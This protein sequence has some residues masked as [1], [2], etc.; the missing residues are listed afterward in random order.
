MNDPY[1]CRCFSID[2]L[3]ID[4]FK[5]ALKSIGFKYTVLQNENGFAFGLVL[6][7]DEYRRM[8]V[9]TDYDGN[10]EAEIEYR[11]N[12]PLEHTQ[13]PSYSAHADLKAILKMIDFN[14]K[15]KF[16]PPLSCL[17]PKPVIV[18]NPT[19]AK[20]LAKLGIIGI[21]ALGLGDHFLNDGKGRKVLE[22]KLSEFLSGKK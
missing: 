14:H 16:F 6:D 21:V 8:H 17:R 11:P 1:H 22:K 19:P 13:V 15:S 4:D 3:D 7:I 9:K 12:Y 5:E 2:D 18:E 10:I 20:T